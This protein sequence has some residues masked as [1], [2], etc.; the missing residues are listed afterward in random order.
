MSQAPVVDDPESVGRRSAAAD[1]G[2][3][4]AGRYA[5][6]LQVTD[7][8][9]VG[10]AVAGAYL[11]RLGVLPGAGL[12]LQPL[13][14]PG[15]G[16]KYLLLSALLVIAW[17]IALALNRSRDHRV[18]GLGPDEYK[19][20]MSSSFQ[21]F[22]V[23]AILAYVSKY[24]LARGYVAVAFPLGIVGLLLSRWMW[25]QWLHAVRR[26]GGWSAR[27]VAVGG[28]DHVRAVVAE[29][30]RAHFAG[31]HVVGVCVPP[32]SPEVRSS[33]GPLPVI[34]GLHDVASAV[35]LVGAGEFLPAMLEFDAGLL[36][37]TVDQ[38][39]ASL[40]AGRHLHEARERLPP[41]T[42]GA[43]PGPQVPRA[44]KLPTR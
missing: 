5:E 36:A 12:E 14:E 35:A 7:L 24:D 9:V 18:V 40:L 6:R 30:D 42:E 27:V 22:G 3:R 39:P 11:W 26:R 23:V 13:S 37:A 2:A 21:L 25:R 29:L 1:E 34:G 19:R 17:M 44:P 20:V 15:S 16:R 32:G 43:T 4:W 10:W 41:G 38:A 31:Y 33:F 28:A 8:L